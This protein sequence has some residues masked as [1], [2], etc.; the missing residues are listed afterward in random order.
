MPKLTLRAAVLA[1]RRAPVTAWGQPTLTASAVLLTEPPLAPRTRVTAAGPDETWYLGTAELTL[2]PGDTQ[3]YLDNLSAQRP[4]VWVALRGADPEQAAIALVTCDP[5]EGG[6][7]SD[8]PALTVEA[9]AL[10]PALRP[11]LDAFIAEHHV[12]MPF[13]KRKRTPQPG[14]AAPRAPRIL[15]PDQTWTARRGRGGSE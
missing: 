6:G 11:V 5:Y 15:P 4:S 9:V 13:K 8:D 2:H 12:D 7:A 1:R 3:H 14:D 10:P